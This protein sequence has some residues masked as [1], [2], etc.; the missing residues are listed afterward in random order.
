MSIRLPSRLPFLDRCRQAFASKQPAAFSRRH[1]RS[2]EVLESRIAPAAALGA[3][4]VAVFAAGGDV[5]GDGKFQPGD[6]I[7][8]TVTITNNG[9]VDLTGVT[10]ND[11]IDPNTNLGAVNVSPLALNDTFTAVA[12]TLLEVGV[13]HGTSPAA[14]VAGSVVGND[15]EFLGDTFTLSKLQA[16]NFSGGTATA[17]SGQGGTVTMNASG[18]FT[19]LPALSFTGTDTFT[20]TIR[21]KGLDGIP[22]NADDLTS[23]GTV[24][25]TVGTQ[26]V[27][28]VDSSYTGANG[29]SDGRSTRPFT[30]LSTT[31]LNGAAGAG[32]VD[33]AGDILYFHT[34]SGTYTT[35]SGG[36]AGLVL[37]SNQTLWGQNE[38]LI[39]GGFTLQGAGTDPTLANASGH[40]VTLNSGNTL[41]GFTIGSVASGSFH[42]TNATA[43]SA[44]A[45]G[46]S[47]LVLSG[48]GG[49]LNI[50][51]GGALSVV[52][53]SATSTGTTGHGIN[54]QNTS[55]SLLVSAGALA[56]VAGTDLL[57]EGATATN[58]IAVNVSGLLITNT[59]G[60][61]IDI[62]HHATGLITIATV[63]DNGGTGISIHDNISGTINFN[64]INDV[65]STGASNAV[66]LAANT[67]ATVNFAGGGLAITTSSGSGFSATGGGT[68][69]V[70]GSANTINSSSGT[71]LNIAATTIGATGLAFQSI[72]AG[73]ASN[74][75]GSGIILDTTGANGGLTV[76]G[77]GGAGSGGTIQHKT[78]ANGTSAGVGIFLNNVGKGVSFTNMQLNDFG[79]FG[80]KG[81]NV[82][83]FKFINSVINGTN[84]DVAG[85]GGV[86]E[87]DIRFDNL[88]G[89]ADITNSTITGG[90]YDN[91][92]IFNTSGTLNRLTVSGGT[93]GST[94]TNGN[95]ALRFEHSGTATANI[96]VTGVTF[97][98]ARGDIF[99]AIAQPGATVDVVFTGN[100][101]SNNNSNIVSGGGGFIVHGG[102]T[103]N[104]D[105]SNNT[106]RDARGRALNIS[107]AATAGAFTGIISGNSIGVAGVDK[108][109]SLEA[110]CIFVDG[111][112]AG[113]MDVVITGNTCNQYNEAG[114]YLLANNQ[115]VNG[116]NA[117]MHAT[118]TNNTT[119]AYTGASSNFAFAGLFADL[120]SSGS[121]ASTMDLV[122]GG[123]AGQKNSFQNG[124]PFNFTDVSLSR[125][126][127]GAFN[128]S[129][130]VSGSTTPAT[131][132][133]DNNNGTVTTSVSGTLVVPSANIVRVLGNP[134]SVYEDGARNI[135]YTFTRTGNTTASQTVSF[136]VG[137]TAAGSDYTQSG[138]ATFA[139][140]SPV[141]TLTFDP[142]ADATIEPDETVILNA[143]AGAGYT[144]GSP[145]GRT[146]TIL[147]DD[148]P[149]IFAPSSNDVVI[150]TP[151][152][153]GTSPVLV[154]HPV[155][156]D[157][158]I[159]SQAELDSLVGAA[160][161]R[162][163]ATGLTPEQSALLHSVTFSVEDLA[164]W[165]LGSASAG[166]IVLDSNA[167]G[168]SWFID[169]TPNDDS[170]F[171]G[172]VATATGG[173]AGRVD[174]LTTVMHELG[175]Q[176]GLDDSYVSSDS[177]NLM[178][179]FIH[180]GERRLPG[181]HQADGVA[182]HLGAGDLDFAVGPINIGSLPIGKSVQVVFTAQ[183]N[184]N[185]TASTITNQGTASSTQTGPVLTDGNAGV[186]GQQPTVT[187]VDFPDVNLSIGSTT[188][189]AEDSGG[190][191]VYTFTRQGPLT[192][193]LTVNFTVSG[194]AVFTG[195]AASDTDYTQSGAASFG[196][197]AGTVT[198][199][200]NSSTATVTIT[201]HADTISEADESVV[202]TLATGPGY[203]VAAAGS[204]SG[205][206]T[207][208]N[209]DTTVFVTGTPGAVFEDSGSTLTYTFKRS[210]QISNSLVVNFNVA[211]SAL[212][213]GNA[214]PDTDF[215]QSGAT[216][217]TG[218]TGTLT[219]APGSDTATITLAPKPDSIVEG[220]ETAQLTIAAGSGYNVDSELNSL[221]GAISNDDAT[222]SVAVTA[223]GSIAEDAANGNFL[224]YTFTRSGYLA[225]AVTVNFTASGSATKD[226]DYG[227]NGASFIGLAGTVN[228]APNS[229]TATV[230]VDPTAD[231]TG[232]LDETVIFTINS[233][234]GYAPAADPAD[235]ATGTI[236]ND[237]TAVSVA[238][239]G[240]PIS[241]AATGGAHVTYTFTRTGDNGA[242]LQINFSA[243]GSASFANDY[244]LLGGDSFS[245]A[246]GLGK[247]TFLAGS[248]TASVTLVPTNDTRVEGDEEAV[249]FVNTG[250]GYGVG[251]S[252]AIGTIT[253]NDTATVSFLTAT[254]S[255]PEGTPSHSVSVKLTTFSP[256]GPA[257]LQNDFT[258]YVQDVTIPGPGMA[259]GGGVDY[260]FSEQGIL[261]SA[262]DTGST[263]TASATIVN[264]T[265]S[266]G[267][268]TF[269]LRLSASSG[270][271]APG[272][273]P[274]DTVTI[275]GT[276]HVVTITDN[277]ID[278][279]VTVN[280]PLTNPVA[281]FGA[282]NVSFTFLVENKGLTD[283][284]NV[285]LSGLFTLPAGVSTYSA[286]P[287]DGIFTPSANGGSWHIPALAVNGAATLSVSFTAGS[288]T[289]G[290]ASVQVSGTAD[291]ADQT[292]VNTV[293]DSTNGSATIDRKSDLVLTKT[294]SP[295]PVGPGAQLT[296]TI[297]VH[298][299][300][301]SDATSASVTD[302]F[303][304]EFT[305]ASWT[306][307]YS[308][309]GAGPA[310]GTG[311]IGATVTGIPSGA[312]V[313][314]TVVGTANAS[315][316]TSFS[317]TASVNSSEETD[318]SNNSSKADTFV[319]GVDLKLTKQADLALVTPSITGNDHILTYTLTY[320][321]GG[322]ITAN[323]VKID[324]IIPANT[325]F[326][327]AH[328]SPGWLD[329]TNNP[330]ANG[331]AA[332]TAIHFAVGSLPV[333]DTGTSITLA[334]KVN[335][336]V[337]AGAGTIDNA[338]DISDNGT[339]GADLTPGDNHATASS[340]LNAAPDLKLLQSADRLLIIRGQT[341]QV[342]YSYSN[343]GNQD[344]SD[345]RITATLPVGTSFDA[346]QST[347][348]WSPIDGTHYLFGFTTL[349]AQG[350]GS[351][352]FAVDLNTT[353]VAGLHQVDTTATI[354]DA[355]AN[356]P[357][358]TPANNTAAN[359][360]NP[361]KIYEGIYV[362]S[363]GIAVPGKFGLP[364]VRVYDP[365]D[366]HE[367]FHFN[368][369]ET[370]YRA[371]VRVAV[372]DINGDGFDDVITTS[373]VG[374]GRLRV[375]NGLTG[376][377]L[378]D[379][380]NYHGPFKNE[381]A[382]FSGKGLDRGAFVAAGDLTGDG[383]ADIVVGTALGGNKVRVFDGFTAQP[384]TFGGTDTFFQPFGKTFRG[385][386]R[387]AVGDVLGD[388]LADLAVAMGYYGSQVKVYD[389]TSLFGFRRDFAALLAPAPQPQPVPVIDFKVGPANYRGGL[390]IALGDLD[391]D[392]K[393][394]II[395]G[396]NW[397]K[398]TLVE[399]FSGLLKD[400]NGKPKVIGE[401]INPFDLDPSKP[402]YALGVRVAAIDINFDGIADI[403]AATGGNNKSRVNI[404][405]GADHTLLRTF[406]GIPETPNS[407]LFVAG[408]AVSPVIRLT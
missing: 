33:G 168:N 161:A 304:V 243:G 242:P 388:S 181:A 254:S 289:T 232:E 162:W 357:D 93:I 241:E 198:F 318:P 324:D 48:T 101:V 25:I 99:D 391:H 61:A 286:T 147:D 206:G 300:G 51:S 305:N 177:A 239:S 139:A 43:A 397:L 303:P 157:D 229:T 273:A 164:G 21:D 34:G 235:H 234:S 395:T 220:D 293:D 64:G 13:T 224:I 134:V 29:A 291:S 155:I 371:S 146:T 158:G 179:G 253:D 377:W 180:Q 77:T 256:E 113:S 343:D 364:T 231:A 154:T 56:N 349:A 14:Q 121:D 89:R 314:F 28:Y 294:D 170:E 325:V 403:I 386:V 389:G 402:K 7:L 306:V 302:L 119:N 160:I 269:Q 326:D 106:F 334:V 237:D 19:Y 240:G 408:T 47:N 194:G 257:S 2:L 199:P 173:A 133:T 404:Y 214:A 367:L 192:N 354:D 40:G 310:S 111:G 290:G 65:L 92:G 381:I 322:F 80:I 100:T 317:N 153:D 115:A 91:I 248:S 311:N 1:A 270:I 102:G 138:S 297:K 244:T 149:L 396:R 165:Y 227:V 73:T 287:S 172:S 339:G 285:D 148:A 205:T 281:G 217:F 278:L 174:A 150:V 114:I 252:P 118:V 222:V 393:L 323:G 79:N 406:Q 135:N 226:T 271:V 159:L 141:A 90:F 126:G 262:G 346:A 36:A 87:G 59:A 196:A 74:S 345:V 200:A 18:N 188:S 62:G 24:T 246:S 112:G 127:T 331:A 260:T 78:G 156:V 387:V 132:I 316:N 370:S 353:R 6:T 288:S 12:N 67:G 175:H 105:V 5:N 213:T 337:S 68:V 359:T 384:R 190:N 26:K 218:S 176:L 376:Q 17:T 151:V 380:P 363:Q 124:D 264:D 274:N 233:G 30:A 52:L 140:G 313:I 265:I 22:G 103:V 96:S 46:I 72:T 362:V 374:T 60:R 10:F 405:S 195:N 38:A 69:T 219:F 358:P 130:G 187:Q 259:T 351:V 320:R 284:T 70:T 41:K 152:I 120:G 95:D 20:Y 319:G 84:G 336:T 45:L 366:G 209:D 308:A 361:T 394:D 185:D 329:V 283:A 104:F 275:D 360:S 183:I 338:A 110:S 23:D 202:L 86:G 35:S 247:V 321:N 369:Y 108:S 223:P 378:H 348:G 236:L 279:K 122:L 193:S 97:T 55:G 221:T 401:P 107:K 327:S 301:P 11:I 171:A 142:T 282:G 385:G 37:E 375:F 261:F 109:G 32:D 372:A 129:Q 379:D 347:S 267:N 356:G 117:T 201:P 276:P 131:V 207:I 307:D 44:G 212:F 128:L 251:A 350:S 144:V 4:K 292:L 189:V 399:T 15:N 400:P 238:V 57:V 137:G 332:G 215:T 208:A 75:A 167:A 355:G 228:F 191:L 42:I 335:A 54:L 225:N 392:G 9:D 383:R 125:I 31:N 63:T 83:G 116:N 169:A 88:L 330:V 280:S 390:S 184:S 258:V 368:A 66:T 342:T 315:S 39:V 268:E 312:D 85:E 98:A 263:K 373:N 365:V 230:T 123:G 143:T 272:A 186:A 249:I 204:I 3:T 94:S 407:A 250:P 255:T 328:S 382:A 8:Y 136:S 216:T 166:H 341:L 245:T 49:L 344:A 27:W 197:S 163:E 298:N 58:T 145:S 398:P 211:G 203:D 50:D 296:Y 53:D 76:T 210:G 340:T 277:D 178:Y 309:G 71:A 352:I 266:E 295:D 299:N 16:V 81:S 333:S 182:P 82:T